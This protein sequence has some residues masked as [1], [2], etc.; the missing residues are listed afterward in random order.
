MEKTITKLGLPSGLL[1]EQTLELFTA[2]GFTL[3]LDKKHYKG[4]IDDANI[5]IYLARDQE[6]PSFVE[7]NALDV[8]IAQ[9]AYLIDQ[10]TKVK[11]I[12]HLNYGVGRWGN[13]KVVL[14]VAEKSAFKTIKDLAGKKVLSRLPNLTKAYFAKNNIKAQVEFTERPSEPKIP[15][16]GDAVVEFTNSGEA[17]KAFGLR[18]IDTLMETSPVLFVSN[19]AFLNKEKRQKIEDLAVLLKGAR[20]AK[21]KVGLMLHAKA[22]ILEKVLKILPAM[23]KPTITQLRGEHIFDVLTIVDRVKLRQIVPDLKQAGATDIVEFPL[24]KVIL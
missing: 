20:L 10:K 11:I 7:R 22:S 13:A 4:V 8:A 17:L 12:E 23:K 18:V 5:E 19:S 15:A 24:N 3:T 14:A 9:E 6:L 21:E 1:Q 16:L 2:A